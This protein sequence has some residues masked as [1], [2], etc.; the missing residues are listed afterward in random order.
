MNTLIHDTG[1][2]FTRELRPVLRD[3]FS[4]V[5]SMIQ[6][7]IFLGLFAPL[8]TQ[9][10]GLGAGS[11]LQ[12]FV[13][14]IVVMSCLFG[15]SMT[16]SN[17]LMEMQTGSHE[18]MLV[19]P[20]SRSSLLMGRALK[21]IVPVLLQAVILVLVVLPF[22]FE[23]HAAGVVVGLAVLAVFCI[24]LGSLSYALALAAKGQDWIFWTVQQTLIFPLLLLAGMLLPVD[25]G[26]GWLQTVSKL[27]PLTYVV[28]V[29][30][31]LFAGT[32]EAGEL[33]T[34]TLAAVA[35]CVFGLWV[36]TRSMRAAD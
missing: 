28:D 31:S 17:L 35:V 24:G 23:L 16:G 5:F 29:E 3:P 18:R 32:F 7:L 6:P 36:G 12:W 9:V 1:I 30:R 10:P 21:E 15:A 11:T 34:G 8:L 22:D 13:P 14:G 33:L 27:N 2:V 19:T 4:V 20:L 26:P 25:A